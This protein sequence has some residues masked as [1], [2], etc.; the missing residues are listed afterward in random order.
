MSVDTDMVEIAQPC[1]PLLKHSPTGSPL[2]SSVHYLRDKRL[3]IY[4]PIRDAVR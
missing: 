4:A 2:I 1:S 3:F